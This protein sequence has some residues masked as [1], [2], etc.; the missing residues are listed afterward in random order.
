M[1]LSHDLS[2]KLW[3][4]S[5]ATGAAGG[6]CGVAGDQLGVVSWVCISCH[7]GTPWRNL[8]LQRSPCCQGRGCPPRLPAPVMACAAHGAVP[9]GVVPQPL[10]LHPFTFSCLG[11]L[12]PRNDSCLSPVC[13]VAPVSC[14]LNVPVRVPSE[15]PVTPVSPARLCHL[16]SHVSAVPSPLLQ[17]RMVQCPFC[18]FRV[19]C[20]SP[21]SP[22]CPLCIP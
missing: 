17:P 6:H 10:P 1:C 9:V 2:S 21:V 19:S 15:F 20:A 4:L 12:C 5:P 7:V 11:P 14:V 18:A 3:V 13:A 22:A 8:P 16:V